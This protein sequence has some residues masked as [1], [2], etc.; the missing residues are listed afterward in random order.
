MLLTILYILTIILVLC[1]CSSCTAVTVALI[2]LPQKTLSSQFILSFVAM[3]AVATAAV[4]SSRGITRAVRF[5]VIS[6]SSISNSSSSS[7]IPQSLSLTVRHKSCGLVGLP[8]IGK[9]TLFNALT[10][11][12]LAQASNYPFTTIEPNTASVAV[13]DALLLSLSRV[14]GS[15]KVLT[16]LV[17]FVDI[18]GLIKDASS[19][20][21]L[22][23]QFL[24]NIRAVDVILHMVRCFQQQDI[25]HV[26]SDVNPVRDIGTIDTE[27]ILADLQSLEKREANVNKKNKFATDA[28]ASTTAALLSTCKQLLNDGR[29]LYDVTWLK[30]EQHELVQSWQLLTT[31]PVVFICNIDDESAA[32]GNAYS[33]AVEE[34]VQET[35]NQHAATTAAAATAINPSQPLTTTPYLYQ[36]K[37]RSVIYIAAA[38]EAEASISFNDDEQSRLEY[39]RESSVSDHGLSKVVATTATLLQQSCFY[40]IGPEEARSWQ[41]NTGDTAL[42]AAGRI[43]SDIQHGFI[44]A[45]VIKSSDF[46]SLKGESGCKAAGKIMTVGKDYVMQVGDIVHFKFNKTKSR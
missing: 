21:G 8:N 32:N 33:K 29:M 23:N 19:G 18:A 22:G 9:S 39:L 7:I 1:Y 3:R 40:T 31:K 5:G 41:I 42:A 44:A 17:E 11:T 2:T 24:N 16:S 46:L 37:K 20:A 27:L 10:N 34:Y 12:Q 6:L 28:A 35:Y 36:P 43:H 26:E 4:T 30:A 38:L 45:D 14:A 13:P 25:I 15:A